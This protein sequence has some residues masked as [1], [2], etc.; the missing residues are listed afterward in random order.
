MYSLATAKP[1]IREKTAKLSAIGIT[2]YADIHHTEAWYAT[3]NLLSQ[4]NQTGTGSEYRKSV[5]NLLTQRIIQIQLAQEFIHYCAFATR[6]NQT[7]HRLIQIALLANFEV[8]Y[9]EFIQHCG[10]LCEG[11][12]QRQNSF[13]LMPTIASPRS[14]DSSA[15]SFAS[16]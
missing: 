6:N 16:V 5:L 2:L 3:I 9:A 7:I 14:V 1:I 13:S 8:R 11:A 12:L 4:Q 15:I 10:M